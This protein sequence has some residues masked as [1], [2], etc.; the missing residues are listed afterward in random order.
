MRANRCIDLC[1]E[2]RRSSSLQTAINIV[3]DAAGDCCGFEK[4]YW[5][6]MVGSF[7]PIF[8]STANVNH[9]NLPLT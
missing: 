6:R 7:F 8:Q 4:T 2:E 3:S 9:A 5:D 1:L